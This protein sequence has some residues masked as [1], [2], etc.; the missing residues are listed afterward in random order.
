MNDHSP[1]EKHEFS[2]LTSEE[3]MPTENI[4]KKNQISKIECE[5]YLFLSDNEPEL[6][7]E[8]N[9]VSITDAK[10]IKVELKIVS[11]NGFQVK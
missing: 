1:M 9:I 10:K 7:D 6:G 5:E 8:N 11:S 4:N 3:N 2:F